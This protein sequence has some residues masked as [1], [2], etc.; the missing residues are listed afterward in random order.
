[1]RLQSVARSMCER[2]GLALSL[3][4]TAAILIG[5]CGSHQNNQ[6]RQPG[7]PL[8]A[9]VLTVKPR[10]AR[11]TEHY[12]AL[13]RSRQ[14]VQVVA[15]VTGV[16]KA[17]HYKQGERVHKGDK[18]FTIQKSQYRAQV[19]QRRA[20]LANAKA[21]RKNAAQTYERRQSLYKKGAVSQHQ[22][23][24]ARAKQRSAKAAV[25]QAK[26]ALDQAQ[27][28]LGYTDVTAP[29]TGEAG[30]REVDIGNLVN[31]GDKLVMITPLSPIEARLSLPVTDAILLGRQ[32]RRDKA[33]R[34]KAVVHSQL[35]SHSLT[36]RI[37]FL[38]STVDPETGT[39]KARATFRNSH[40]FFAPGQYVQVNLK[41]LEKPNVLAV[42]QIAVAQ[43]Q[44]GARLFVLDGR[45]RAQPKPVELGDTFKIPGAPFNPWVI[46]TQ[47][48]KRGGRV[49]VNH[50]S[51]VTSGRRIKVRPLTGPHKGGGH[52]QGSSGGR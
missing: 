11:L 31:P 37:D 33:P 50:I 15:R 40:R 36:G 35:T 42:P 26:A 21:T 9:Q 6:H 48:L 10:T 46:V 14:Q 5:G 17:R 43:G 22:L 30:L 27:L 4:A 3:I 45:N 52:K 16:L 49:V 19:R 25:R 51:S 28:N 23:Q 13:L 29:V 44:S 2:R 39:V 7:P 34:V 20:N 12:P 47:G 41:G 38:A 1:M 24:N 32:R 8:A 18:L